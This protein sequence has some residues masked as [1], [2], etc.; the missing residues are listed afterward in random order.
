M[1]HNFISKIYMEQCIMPYLMHPDQLACIDVE[2]KWN[3]SVQREYYYDGNIRY[4]KVSSQLDLK[5]TAQ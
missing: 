3:F 1:R 4:S 5:M 2:N